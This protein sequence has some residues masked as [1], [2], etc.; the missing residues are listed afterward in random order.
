MP[1]LQPP[2]P[3]STVMTSIDGVTTAVTFLEMYRGDQAVVL[4]GDKKKLRMLSKLSLPDQ[5]PA[6]LVQNTEIIANGNVPL[7]DA[8]QNFSVVERVEMTNMLA[9]SV[10][11]GNVSSMILCGSSGMGKS[12]LIIDSLLR[13]DLGEC[14]SCTHKGYVTARGLYEM[15]YDNNGKICVFDD[16]DSIFDNEVS[17]NLLKAALDT[18]SVRKVSW[19]SSKETAGY[20]NEFIFDG[21]VIC[22]SNRN[23]TKIP[24]AFVGRSVYTDLTMNAEEKVERIHQLGSKLC[25]DIEHSQVLECVEFIDSLKHRIKNLNL[26]TMQMVGKM[27]KAQPDHWHKIAKYMVLTA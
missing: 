6:E 13:H 14:D 12:H 3:N 23:I 2:Q 22:I 4:H 25:P 15:L 8:S 1:L 16:C 17:A 9:D 27:R 10:I 5:V 21:A 11:E 20:P 24:E 18:Y 7:D 19:G 26:R